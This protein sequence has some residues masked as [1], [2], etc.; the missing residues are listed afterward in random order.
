MNGGYMKT[1]RDNSR[2]FRLWWVIVERC[3]TTYV[4]L[5]FMFVFVTFAV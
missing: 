3:V 5:E 2:C 4:F 1:P